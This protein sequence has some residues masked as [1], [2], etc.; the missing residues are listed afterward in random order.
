RPSGTRR[1]APRQPIAATAGRNRVS[2]GTPRSPAGPSTSPMTW[3]VP[4]IV[5]A[6]SRIAAAQ[7]PGPVRTAAI[8]TTVVAAIT[9]SR[10]PPV[11]PD[12]APGRSGRRRWRVTRGGPPGSPIRGAV[13][14]VIG[15]MVRASAGDPIRFRPHPCQQVDPGPGVQDVGRGDPAP[16][17]LSDAP[18]RVV[19]LAGVVRVR[20]DRED[21]TRR[22]G[23]AR[24]L[25]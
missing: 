8:P 13:E 25:G 12:A 6:S 14:L 19:E 7:T 9:R 18:A 4:R 11:G 1:M 2:I 10:A 17:G 3:S 22:H 21:A 16:A 15:R 20:V 24:P 23:P 5:A